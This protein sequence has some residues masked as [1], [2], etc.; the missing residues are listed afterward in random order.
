M[1]MRHGKVVATL[2]EN[3]EIIGDVVA[4][5]DG[6][7]VGLKSVNTQIG[8]SDFQ[9]MIDSRHKASS[10]AYNA[11]LNHED[12]HIRAYLSVIDDDKVKITN[13]INLAANSV[14]PIFVKQESDTASALDLLNEK[15]QSHPE[16]I[17]MNQKIQAEQELR[18]NQVDTGIA[19]YLK[20]C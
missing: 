12:A 18:N 11:I 19:D 6:F 15:L 5:E 16:I 8:Y 9:V 2:T 1:D 10:C 3:F 7:C 13:A 4:M 20:E 17:L 14:M